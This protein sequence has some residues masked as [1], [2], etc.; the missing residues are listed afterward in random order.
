MA[1]RP[2]IYADRRLKWWECM[3]VALRLRIPPREVR[4]IEKSVHEYSET[5][6]S[7]LSDTVIFG[8]GVVQ[9][10]DNDVMVKKEESDG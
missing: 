3:I 6:R 4:M 9:L 8:Y 10:T 5:L 1:E 7:V 2:I